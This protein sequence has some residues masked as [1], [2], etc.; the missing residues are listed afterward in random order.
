MQCIS[1]PIVAGSVRSL[2]Q[3]GTLTNGVDYRRERNLLQQFFHALWDILRCGLHAEEER[4]DVANKLA[5]LA[6]A[7]QAILREIAETAP[8][9]L[10]YVC[11]LRVEGK[12][13]ILQQRFPARHVSIYCEDNSN[14]VVELEGIDFVELKNS[15]AAQRLVDTDDDV[16]QHQV[17]MQPALPRWDLAANAVDGAM[18]QQVKQLFAGEGNAQAKQTIILHATRCGQWALLNLLFDQLRA[19][20]QRVII[21]D[22]DFGRID[23]SKLDF[24]HCRAHRARL[25]RQIGS[26]GNRFDCNFS[27]ADLTGSVIRDLEFIGMDWSCALLDGVIID[28][29]DFSHGLMIDLVVRNA[30][31]GTLGFRDVGISLRDTDNLHLARLVTTIMQ[32]RTPAS[33]LG[34]AFGVSPRDFYASFAGIPRRAPATDEPVSRMSQQQMI[35]ET[36]DGVSGRHEY[37]RFEPGLFALMGG[38]AEEYGDLLDVTTIDN[39]VFP[40]ALEA[41][42]TR[43]LS[44][45][46]RQHLV[47]IAGPSLRRFFS[48]N[49]K[50]GGRLY[51]DGV[52]FTDQLA[53]HGEDFGDCNL[54]GA[55][56]KNVSF[57]HS[58][59][60]GCDLRRAQF[61]QCSFTSTALD[62]VNLSGTTIR[63]CRF[64]RASLRYADLRAV[65]WEHAT[66]V[67]V[68]M[69]EAQTDDPTLLAVRDYSVRTDPP[70]EYSDRWI[71]GADS[72]AKLGFDKPEQ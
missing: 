4:V 65:T 36:L 44:Q 8:Y 2:W 67:S 37:D 61:E 12:R 1:T 62:H 9:Q 42:Q 52:T 27:H 18:W 13:Y 32:W 70:Y 60:S 57:S 39:D 21:D 14:I 31:L 43:H 33:R 64:D 47:D 19:A 24:R 35:G 46:I 15:V 5:A 26:P 40:R 48:E 28:M 23:F 29:V 41:L 11:R 59:M 69:F 30:R 7:E 45:N 66:F 16:P 3:T 56:F 72:N 54:V 53:M 10:D 38:Y 17:A 50:T 51:L 55:T 22:V 63:H 68:N 20:G 34:A 58:R 71:S 6:A 25:V 49:I